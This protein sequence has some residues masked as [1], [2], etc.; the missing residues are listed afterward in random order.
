MKCRAR[1]STANAACP[2]FRW[3]TSGWMPSAASSRQPPSPSASSCC[4]PDFRSAAVQLA[5]DSAVG[6]EIRRVVRVEQVELHAADLDLPCAQPE[7]IAGQHDLQPQPFAVRLPQRRDR[8]LAG[9]VVGEQ[10]PL[11][12]VPVNQLPEIS[13]LIEQPDGDHRHAEI[14]RRLELVAG[15]VAEAA[16]V[17]RQRF[18]QHELHAEIG[19]A[20]QRRFRVRL[21]KPRGRQ[22]GAALGLDQVAHFFADARVRQ[23]PLEPVPRHRLQDHPR[24]LRQV[25]ERGVQPPPELV[26]M[27]VPRPAQVQRQ[28]RQFVEALDLGGQKGM[29]PD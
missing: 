8:Q 22:R 1:S 18:A 14:A 28:F 19:D 27:V 29:G 13:L 6:G 20:G 9:I 17:D 3:Q 7:R 4:K 25:P 16:G 12:A 2:S 26:G 24:V 5:G 15:H 21:L 11:R 23:Q 10:R